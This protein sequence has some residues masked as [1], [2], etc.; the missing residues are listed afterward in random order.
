MMMVPTGVLDYQALSSP[1][2]TTRRPFMVVC[3][4]EPRSHSNAM[5]V[6][7]AVK[8]VVTEER[9][10]SLL[11]KVKQCLT[12]CGRWPWNVEEKFPVVAEV[13]GLGQVEVMMRQVLVDG[14]K[15]ALG[16]E[17]SDSKVVSDW[18]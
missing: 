1:S 12:Q 4:D 7:K 15:K 14:L 16:L 8:A 9:Y 2:P 10:G 18:Y 5:A 13:K 17:R 6:V 3:V 11:A